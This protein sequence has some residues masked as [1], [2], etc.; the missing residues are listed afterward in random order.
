MSVRE[1]ACV[2]VSARGGCGEKVRRRAARAESA[3]DGRGY[4]QFAFVSTTASLAAVATVADARSRR[5]I[6]TS[7]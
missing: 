3:G 1:C 6:L 5:S 7:G 4:V 2:C